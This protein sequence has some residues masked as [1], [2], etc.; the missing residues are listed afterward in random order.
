MC[1]GGRNVI[2]LPACEGSRFRGHVHPA[3]DLL[4]EH[5]LCQTHLNFYS[6]DPE[7]S[8]LETERSRQ[9]FEKATKK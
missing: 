2:L 9:I 6:A 1:N 4:D 7:D 3:V 5:S 8:L